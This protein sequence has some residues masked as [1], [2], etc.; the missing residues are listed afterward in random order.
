MN[1]QH[2]RTTRKSNKPGAVAE[3]VVEYATKST[4][5]SCERYFRGLTLASYKT[6]HARTDIHL[7]SVTRIEVQL[8]S[9][10]RTSN[11]TGLSVLPILR[12]R[13]CHADNYSNRDGQTE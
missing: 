13:R 12:P 4:E 3:L 1:Y 8:R 6:V 7:A 2:R 9:A 5:Y 10:P 11:G